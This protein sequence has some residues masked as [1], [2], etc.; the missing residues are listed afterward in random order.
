MI[1]AVIHVKF[2]QPRIHRMML[3][4]RN[5]IIGPARIGGVRHQDVN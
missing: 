1:A 2:N 3:V 5:N 4:L